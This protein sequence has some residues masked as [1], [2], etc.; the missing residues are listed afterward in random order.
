MVAR[1]IHYMSPLGRQV[2][3]KPCYVVFSEVE[4]KALVAHSMKKKIAPEEP[5]PL[6]QAIRMLVKVG[7]FQG[8]KS[9]GEPGA[10]TL[11]RGLQMLSILA[12]IWRVMSSP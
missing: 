9:D 7:G 10:E 5:P 6:Q 8:H 4:W 1:R 3:D 12:G 11:W 2:P